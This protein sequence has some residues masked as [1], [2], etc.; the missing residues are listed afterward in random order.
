MYSVHFPAYDMSETL[1]E[2]DAPKQKQKPLFFEA[3]RSF[4]EEKSQV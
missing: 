3:H 2:R 1:E 4:H